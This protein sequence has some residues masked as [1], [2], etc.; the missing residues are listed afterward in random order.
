MLAGWSRCRRRGA[1]YSG[2]IGD[3]GY[4]NRGTPVVVPMP[5]GAI[6]LDVSAGEGHTCAVLAGST[7]ACWGDDRF[8]QLGDGVLADQGPVAPLS[9]CP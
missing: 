5:G 7:V 6:V 2:E 1:S 8:G 4:N 3:G 9:R